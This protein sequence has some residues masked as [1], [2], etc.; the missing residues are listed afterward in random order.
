MTEHYTDDLDNQDVMAA[1]AEEAGLTDDDLARITDDETTV[2]LRL[3]EPITF[4]ASKLE[5]E[6]T[7]EELVIP[8]GV[9]GKHLVAMDKAEGEMGKTLALIAALARIPVHAAR[10]LDGRDVDLAL[11]A[12][13]PFL[14]KLR[15]TGKR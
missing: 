10:E 15:G 1:H 12:I 6:R 7:I 13:L 3:V 5:G 14:P 4:K 11:Y 2:T 9:K 8:K